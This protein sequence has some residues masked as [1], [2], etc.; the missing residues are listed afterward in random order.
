MA[1]GV[2]WCC[3]KKELFGNGKANH[4]NICVHGV[5]THTTARHARFPKCIDHKMRAQAHNHANSP[6]LVLSLFLTRMIPGL[7]KRIQWEKTMQ[8]PHK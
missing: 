2:Q 6:S 1:G 3:A 5:R 4:G 7:S 8:P